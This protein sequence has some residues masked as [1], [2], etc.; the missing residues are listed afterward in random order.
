MAIPPRKRR[1]SVFANDAVCV[2][3]VTTRGE[4][5]TRRI[6]KE[7]IAIAIE[8]IVDAALN[9]DLKNCE[10]FAFGYAAALDMFVG[11]T[12]DFMNPV[13]MVIAAKRDVDDVSRSRRMVTNFLPNACQ[14]LG[15]GK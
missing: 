4:T 1:D 11:G 5:M 3:R 14:A 12:L 6:S 15:A 8:S 9:G 2:V 13:G 10:E 7:D